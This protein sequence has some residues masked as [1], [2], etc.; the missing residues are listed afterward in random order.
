MMAKKYVQSAG[1]KRYGK[2]P[3]EKREVMK[4][5]TTGPPRFKMARAFKASKG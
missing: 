3:E 2:T 4:P 5:K 1:E